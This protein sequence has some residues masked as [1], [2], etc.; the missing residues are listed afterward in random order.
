MANAIRGTPTGVHTVDLAHS[1]FDIQLGA[2]LSGRALAISV[3]DIDNTKIK[4]IVQN[5][6]RLKSSPHVFRK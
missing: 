6:L 1:P 5:V 2:W 4:M 3:K